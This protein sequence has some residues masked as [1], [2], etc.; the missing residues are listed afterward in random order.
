[1]QNTNPKISGGRWGPGR[2]A[3]CHPGCTLKEIMDLVSGI[4]G[5]QGSSRSGRAVQCGLCVC[6]GLVSSWLTHTSNFSLLCL[7]WQL[8]L[9]YSTWGFHHSF[10]ERIP[11]ATWICYSSE[12]LDGVIFNTCEMVTSSD[13]SRVHYIDGRNKVICQIISI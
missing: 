8:S 2:N 4:T 10:R 1:M 5:K 3:S 11:P 7:F 6:P 13:L 12:S 9:T